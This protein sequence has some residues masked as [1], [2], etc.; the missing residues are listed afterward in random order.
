M[1]RERICIGSFNFDP[2]SVSYNTELGFVIR[3]PT[4]CASMKVGLLNGWSVKA[5]RLLTDPVFPTCF[6]LVRKD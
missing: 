3:S 1:D 6:K 2:R 4:Q 5:T